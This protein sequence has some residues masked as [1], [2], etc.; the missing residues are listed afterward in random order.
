MYKQKY[1]KYKYKYNQEKYKQIGSYAIKDDD[2][3]KLQLGD[4]EIIELEGKYAK[5]IAYIK[6]MINDISIENVLT[7]EQVIPI[8]N[9]DN[10][11]MHII[12]EMLKSNLQPDEAPKSPLLE[13]IRDNIIS[14]IEVINYLEI[15]VLYDVIISYAINIYGKSNSTKRKLFKQKLIPEIY[16]KI[17]SEYL[18]NKFNLP[19]YNDLFKIT[20]IKIKGVFRSLANKVDLLPDDL[21][22]FSNLNEIIFGAGFTGDIYPGSIPIGVT[23]IRF[24]S[25]HSNSQIIKNKT[26]NY[27]TSGEYIFGGYNKKFAKNVFPSSLKY[28]VLGE[29]Y[30]QIIDT[31]ILPESLT[32]LEFKGPYEPLNWAM[33]PNSLTDII[34]NSS[35]LTIESIG[36][37]DNKKDIVDEFLPKSIIKFTIGHRSFIFS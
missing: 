25:W 34:I 8:A 30:N 36:S 32:H 1:E 22:D 19:R 26:E 14:L 3:V 5:K 17:I 29:S 35:Q 2:I 28:L 18:I 37:Y 13:S 10:N 15:D 24:I 20:S 21:N 12:I 31:G 16:K 11:I 23:S 27:V 9:I 7:S 33:L 6:N 4:S